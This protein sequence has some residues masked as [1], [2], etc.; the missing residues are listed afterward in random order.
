MPDVSNTASTWNRIQT[1]VVTVC[2]EKLN[3]IKN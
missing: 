3:T 1:A 2:H